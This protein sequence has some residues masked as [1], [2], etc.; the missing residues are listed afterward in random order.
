MVEVGD[1]SLTLNQL[2]EVIPDNSSANDSAALAERYIQ[3][4][5]MEQL[6]VMKAEQSLSDEKQNFESLIENYRK[7]LLTYAYEQ[8]WI[9]QKLDTV[10]SKEEI[11]KYYQENE[12]NFQLKDYIVKVKFCA[13]ASDSKNIALMKKLFYS[14]K[15]EDLVKW[16]QMCVDIGASYYF[17]EDHWMLWDECI[18]QVP[19]EVYDVESFLKRQKPVEIER[20]NNLYLIAITDYQLSGT[21]SPL[22]F[23]IEKIRSMII[24]RRKLDLLDAMRKDLYAKGTQDNL[25]K[26]YYGKK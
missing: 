16:E 2:M 19:L 13:L 23:E 14:A 10:V 15:D 6:I 4:W 1:K 12:K 26:I 21:R 25:V 8:E 5:T 17:N 3:D 20:D 9:R 24:N 11:E 18:K 7:S 22:S